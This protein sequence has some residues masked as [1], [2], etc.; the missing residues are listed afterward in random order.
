MFIDTHC[1][2]DDEKFIDLDATI[3]EIKKAGVDTVINIG[4]DEKTTLHGKNLSEKYDCVYFASGFHPSEIKGLT[5][6]SLDKIKE[7]ALHEKC[8][9]I[10]EIGLDYHWEPYDKEKQ[11]EGFIKQIELANSLD[12]PIS[13]HSRDATEDMLNLL[14]SHK[15]K[16]GGVM[17]CFSGSRETAKILLDL[18]FYISFAGTLTFKNARNLVEVAEFTPINRCLTETDSPYLA[19]VPHRGEMNTP[20][21][22]PYV[23]KRLAEIKKISVE[24]VA[25]QVKINAKQLFYKIK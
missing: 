1:H 7:F 15:I 12:L 25:K 10:G 17:H 21:Y 18:G 13:V 8:V 4:C 23:T 14:K 16:K 11:I 9:A 24:E 3:E 5:D 20:A 6:K 22:V 19:P 2:I